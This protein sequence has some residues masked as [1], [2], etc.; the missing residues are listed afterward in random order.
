MRGCSPE[1]N[2]VPATGDASVS[3]ARGPSAESMSTARAG[4]NGLP[5]TGK[6]WPASLPESVLVPGTG[7][8]GAALPGRASSV[9]KSAPESAGSSR[10]GVRP[11]SGPPVPTD[12]AGGCVP[13][14]K[15]D[16]RAAKG[17][18]ELSPER[19]VVGTPL[20]NPVSSSGVRAVLRISSLTEQHQA[21]SV[22]LDFTLCDRV[23][24]GRLPPR[25]GG[26]A[27]VGPVGPA[28]APRGA[29]RGF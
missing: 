21:T 25:P 3:G 26:S 20:D 4:G 12:F 29:R 6:V 19:V 7:G 17:L 27:P 13:W 1:G 11:K 22:P 8:S 15:P 28:P 24:S 18:A 23:R 10:T 16:R 2:D 9:S 5:A 14:R